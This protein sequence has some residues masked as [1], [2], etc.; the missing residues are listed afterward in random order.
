M[1]LRNNNLYI[2]Q[3]YLEKKIRDFINLKN[4]NSSIKLIAAI[5]GWNA[6]TTEFSRMANNATARSNFVNKALNLTTKYGFD[7]IDIDWE[8]PV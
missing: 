8:F 1:T 6:G 3:F 5:G 2:I 4:Q 7:G